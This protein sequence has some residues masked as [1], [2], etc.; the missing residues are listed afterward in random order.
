MLKVAA[1]S[2]ISPGASM[3]FK[4]RTLPSF[5][6]LVHHAVKDL[7]HACVVISQPEM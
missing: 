3:S 6:R 7:P 2:E 5:Y 4:G 1:N